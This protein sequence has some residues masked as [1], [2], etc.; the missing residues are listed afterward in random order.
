MFVRPSG[1]FTD[2]DALADTL[3]RVNDRSFRLGDIATIKRG[4]DDPPVTQMRFGGQPVLGIGITMQPGGDVI[5]LGKALDA[6]GRRT[7]RR[8]CPR[9]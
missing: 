8:I 9:G 2:I 6:Q 3:I 1:Q 7:A 5:R 4:Y